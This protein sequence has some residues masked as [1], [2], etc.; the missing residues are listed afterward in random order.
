[1]VQ[2]KKKDLRKHQRLPRPYRV[3]VRELTF[4]MPKRPMFSSDCCDI[5]R[6]GLSMEMARSLP[7]G[8]RVQ[9]S[10][11]IPLLNKFSPGFYKPWE[12]E[13]DQYFQAIAEVAWCKTVRGN[14]LVGMR[15][16]NADPDMFAAL[17]GLVKK[18]VSG[19]K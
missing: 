14:Y 13:A 3:E 17:D 6:G 18:A 10:V 11:H 7:T 8:T 5:S 4:P 19:R 2:D 16:V 9:V 15:F 1:M 12:N